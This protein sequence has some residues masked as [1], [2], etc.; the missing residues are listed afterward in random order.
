MPVI[1]ITACRKLED[2][3][4]SVLH[5]G[6]EVVVLEPGGDPASAFEKVDGLL[7]TGGGDVDPALYG[8]TPHA[9][10]AAAEPGRDSVEIGLG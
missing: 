1:G 5:A 7:L 8:E 10:L 9:R 3:R 6:G 4:Q 2:Y